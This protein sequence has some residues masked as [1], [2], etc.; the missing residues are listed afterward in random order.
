M[1]KLYQTRLYQT[2]RVGTNILRTLKMPDQFEAEI[3]FCHLRLPSQKSL[4]LYVPYLFIRDLRVFFLSTLHF[5]KIHSVVWCE[6]FIQA[7]LVI[8]YNNYYIKSQHY[9]MLFRNNFIPLWVRWD[10]LSTVRKYKRKRH[11][12]HVRYLEALKG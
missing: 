3:R 4:H 2:K 6:C 10:A 5:H 9:I 12:K 8:Y 11:F 7:L 1:Y